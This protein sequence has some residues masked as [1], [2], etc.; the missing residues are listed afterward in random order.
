MEESLRNIT[1]AVQRLEEAI[2]M[3]KQKNSQNKEKIRQLQN[4]IKT[5]YERI[6]NAIETAK[7]QSVNQSEQGEEICLSL[8]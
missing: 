4:V 7:K 1:M 3:E 5:S 8:S 6:N 2:V